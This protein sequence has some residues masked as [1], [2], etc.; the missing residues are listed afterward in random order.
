MK[1]NNEVICHI[2]NAKRKEA[3]FKTT[4]FPPQYTY[5][6]NSNSRTAEIVNMMRNPVRHTFL[7]RALFLS[8]LFLK[9]WEFCSL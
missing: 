4:S 1:K 9:Y 5:C 3:I 2:F 6:G 7:S 8:L